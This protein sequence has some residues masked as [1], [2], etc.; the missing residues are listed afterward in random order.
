[1]IKVVVSNNIERG[2]IRSDDMFDLESMPMPLRR[3][4]KNITVKF[5]VFDIKAKKYILFTKADDCTVDDR[6][7]YTGNAGMIWFKLCFPLSYIRNKNSEN[8]YAGGQKS[9]NECLKTYKKIKA[10]DKLD[11]SINPMEMFT[12]NRKEDCLE[13]YPLYQFTQQTYIALQQKYIDMII[14]YYE[15][16]INALSGFADKKLMLLSNQI[17]YMS[18]DKWISFQDKVDILQNGGW[19]ILKN[20]NLNVEYYFGK[21]EYMSNRIKWQGNKIG[22]PQNNPRKIEPLFDVYNCWYFSFDTLKNIYQKLNNDVTMEEVHTEALKLILELIRG[23]LEY[24]ITDIGCSITFNI[25]NNDNKL[26]E[27]KSMNLSKE[28]KIARFFESYVSMVTSNVVDMND[29]DESGKPHYVF[30]KYCTSWHNGSIKPENVAGLYVTKTEH[31]Y[32]VNMATSLKDAISKLGEDTVYRYIYIDLSQMDRDFLN[33][34]KESDIYAGFLYGVEGLVN[35]LLR[36]IARDLN[37][38]YIND[39]FDSATNTA[40]DNMI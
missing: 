30:N 32:S 35:D 11:D 13:I 4:E 34:R 17:Y 27:D 10:G 7:I 38:K 25:F 40:F 37:V 14:E 24:I 3:D 8:L 16:N 2:L 18:N 26:I 5:Y 36:F 29:T 15:K 6:F 21:A 23:I 9:I 19:Y 31:A 12:V 28:D 1:M 22:H 39:A 33:K 20:N